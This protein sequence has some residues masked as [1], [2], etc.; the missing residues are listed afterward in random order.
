MRNTEDESETAMGDAVNAA[1]DA[2][3]DVFISYRRD[4]GLDLAR[5]IAYWFRANDIKCFMDQTEMTSGKFNE[6]IYAAIDGT[7]Y[8]LLLVTE[9]A[10]ERCCTDGDWVRREIEYAIKRGKGKKKF[11]VPITPLTDYSAALPA[12]LPD[13]LS[14]LKDIEASSFDRFKNFESTMR[15]MV[16]RQMKDLVIRLD[17]TRQEK[18]AWLCN[19]IRRYKRNDGTI[20][21][22]E[23]SDLELEARRY[24]IEDRLQNLINIE[25]ENWRQE[26][27]KKLLD[28]AVD[29]YRLAGGKLKEQD[30]EEIKK[31]ADKLKIDSGRVNDL[32]LCVERTIFERNN[33]RRSFARRALLPAAIF[34][35]LVVALSWLHGRRQGGDAASARA[36]REILRLK[37]EVAKARQECSKAGSEVDNLKLNGAKEIAALS[38]ERDVAA[39][40]A[41]DAKAKLAAAVETASA[42]DASRTAAERMLS[43]AKKRAQEIELSM[44]AERTARRA[45]EAKNAEQSSELDRVNK[46]MRGIEEENER[47]RKNLETLRRQMQVDA[48]HDT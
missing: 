9:H 42:A 23:R 5:S 44:E 33:R 32:I 34:V 38:R 48:L 1:P 41:K 4:G 39:N 28:W 6:Q 27:E 10:L 30:C 26:Q 8:F 24:G 13:S 14:D 21:E 18:E 22:Q 3:Y 2:E 7:K 20:D 12:N 36:E 25:E 17:L 35:L 11:I 15:E 19:A 46:R 16:S 37:A 40:E 29:T 47:L 31:R 43:D 45:V